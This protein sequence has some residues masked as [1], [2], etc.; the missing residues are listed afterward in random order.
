MVNEKEIKIEKVMEVI[1][2]REPRYC[3]IETT[4]SLP[5]EAV[6]QIYILLFDKNASVPEKIPLGYVK[7]ISPDLKNKDPVRIK[8]IKQR[9][10]GDIIKIKAKNFENNMDLKI[11]I[12]E[13]SAKYT[14]WHLAI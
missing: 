14:V 2:F 4:K 6:A 9:N 5:P 11:E 10:K 7:K 1:D 8:V 3:W 12:F 13:D